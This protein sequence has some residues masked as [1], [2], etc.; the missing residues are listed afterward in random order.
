MKDCMSHLWN[1]LSEISRH[2]PELCKTFAG[3]EWFPLIFM[4]LKFITIINQ[5]V[6]IT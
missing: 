1:S 4:A 5:S 6:L 2:K 3:D